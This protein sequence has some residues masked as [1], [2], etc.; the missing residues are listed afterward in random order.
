[1]SESKISDSQ[2]EAQRRYDQKT[3]MVSVKYTLSELEEYMQLKEYLTKTNQ[4]MNGFVKKLIR[5][6][7]ASGKGEIYERPL[8]EKLHRTQTYYNYKNIGIDDVQPLIDCLGESVTRILLSRYEIIFEKMVKSEK[9]E[10]EAKL[11]VWI[12]G[13]VRRGEQG[14]FDDMRKAEKYNILKN[15]LSALFNQKIQIYV[16][17][18]T[19]CKDLKS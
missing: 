11:L 10:Y 12:E 5:E 6:Y 9:E 15:E 16:I 17:P 4:S 19:L 14:E 18:I 7:F 13:V 8:E 2:R 1:M 3:K